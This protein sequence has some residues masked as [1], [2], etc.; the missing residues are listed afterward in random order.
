MLFAIIMA[1]G[2]GTRFWPRS[3]R[4]RPKQLLNLHGD[5]TMLQQTVARIAPLVAPERVLIIT[6]ADQAEATRAQLPDLPAENVIAEPCPRDTAPCVGLAAQIVARRDPEGTMI[7]MPADHVIQPIDT[8]LATVKA[9]VAVIDADPSAL[10]TFGIKPTRPETGYGYIERGELL[11][12]RDGVAVNR[13]VQFREKPDRDTAERFLASGNFAWNS[14]IF[15]WRAKTI[16]GEIERHRPQ[17]GAALNRVGASIGTPGEADVLAFEF[18]RMERTPIDKAVMEKAENVKVLEVRYDWNDVGDWRALKTLIEADGSG[19]TIQGDV[20]ARDTTNSIILSN[21]G[22]LIA[23]LGLDD[24][25]IVQAG[26]ATLV[27]RRDQ[28]D[29]LKGLVES[30]DERG[31]GSYL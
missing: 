4:N 21:D 25:V 17:L 16:L 1:G 15:L 5:A 30:L 7:V 9:A 10:V 26:K 8:F 18:P 13:V 20:I 28:L 6:G 22:G 24:V 23:T 2:S 27:A 12:T 31:Y 14:G 19:N 11:E 29:K 3:R